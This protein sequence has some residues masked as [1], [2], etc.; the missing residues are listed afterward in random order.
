MKEF[1]AHNIL[2]DNDERTMGDSPLLCETS[3]WKSVA[4]TVKLFFGDRKLRIVDLGCLEGGYAVEFARLGH[5]VLGVEAREENIKSCLYVKYNLNLPNLN[6]IKDDVRNLRNLGE[7]DIVFCYGLLYHLDNPVNFIQSMSKASKSMMLLNTHYAVEHDWRY[8]LGILNSRVIAPIQK[9]TKWFEIERNY[10]L[11]KITMHE[12]YRGRWYKE[13]NESDSKETI[14]NMLWASY[15]NH[16][17][18]WLCKK[19][20]MGAIN[21]YGF[22]HVFEQQDFADDLQDNF[23]EYHNR[24]MFVAIK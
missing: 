6:F 21:D 16:K 11:S 20:L 13:W 1:T 19:D 22:N 4:K 24:S 9:R 17:S 7:F 2:L 5:D 15:N 23:I 8:D 12:G 14:G 18:F 3:Q 10:R